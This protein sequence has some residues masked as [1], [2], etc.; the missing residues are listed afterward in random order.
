VHNL[1]R[2]L[3][4]CE[5]RFAHLLK[6][7]GGNVFNCRWRVRD[8]GVLEL[9]TRRVCD[10]SVNLMHS[11]SRRLLFG[12]CWRDSMCELR[13]WDLWRECGLKCG[14]RVALCSWEVFELWSECMLE[15]RRGVFPGGYW[16]NLVFRGD[17][18]RRGL[19][20][21]GRNEFHYKLL[22]LRRR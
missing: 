17:L 12:N 22:E 7:R 5:L 8:L 14:L 18:R 20:H 2:G 4:L 9:Y 1:C 16:S 10:T 15:L 11:V 13:C 21:Y 6:L 19:W 3:L